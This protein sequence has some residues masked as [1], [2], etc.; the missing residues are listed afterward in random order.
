MAR[1]LTPYFDAIKRE[2]EANKE[3]CNTF[4]YKQIREAIDNGTSDKCDDDSAKVYFNLVLPT[5]NEIGYPMHLIA[6]RLDPFM[7]IDKLTAKLKLI[8]EYVLHNRIAYLKYKITET[9][10]SA[11]RYEDEIKK[12]EDE[13]KNLY[14]ESLFKEAANV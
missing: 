2:A 4:P 12:C 7:D 11:K 1:S 3:M 5:A 10:K 6:Q 14:K 8:K 13:L 9:P